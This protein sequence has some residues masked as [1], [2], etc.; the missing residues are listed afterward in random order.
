MKK[1]KIIILSLVSVVV[2]YAIPAPKYPALFS[3]EKVRSKKSK[4]LYD[5]SI[6]EKI[7]AETWA[8]ANNR[9]I[10]YETDGVLHELM[11]LENGKPVYYI[12]LNHNAAISTAANLVRDI[13]PYNLNGSNITV[14]VWD[15]GSVLSTHREFDGRV[16]VKDASTANYHATHVGGT[17]GAKGVTA[18]AKGM[19]P[20]SIIDSYD[21]NSDE[22]EMANRAASAPN[23]STKIYVSNHSY[24]TR[25][26]WYGTYWRSNITTLEEPYFGQYGYWT[27]YWDEIAYNAPYYLACKSSGNDRNDNPSNGDSITYSG[28]GPITY[29][30]SIHPGGDGNYK[31]GYDCIPTYG[32]AK[33]ILTVGAVNDAVFSGMRNLG[34]ATISSFSSWGP[35]DD[36]RIKPD[37]VGNGVGLYSCDDDHN[38]D[39]RSMSGTSMSSPNIC[40]SAALLIQHYR[41]LFPGD[42]MRSST[43]KGVI[44]HTADDI[45]RPGP[46]YCY[47]WGLMNTK[48]AADVI[49][50]SLTLS[51][52]TTFITEGLLD[53]GN[54]DDE[55]SFSIDGTEPFKATICW[56]D[57]PGTSTSSHDSRTPVLV[58]DL[59]LRIIS[60]NTTINY[61]FILD[62]NNPGNNATTGDNIRDNVEQ[63]I[64]NTGATPGSYNVTI[65]H[66][67]LSSI[68]GS[69][70][71]YSL[72]VS[73]AI[74]EPVGFLIF[75][76]LFLIYYFRKK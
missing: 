56:T 38:A 48:D 74:P 60:P 75:N 14:G 49:E 40:G 47:G 68:Y 55:F 64:I 73:G 37:I 5:K 22:A 65:N 51:D 66:K 19:A 17:I 45:G 29:D 54:P 59:D 27:R 31:S 70:Q 30:S 23:Q 16:T 50:K 34:F 58:N 26:G 42:D 63:V 61:P 2:L 44:L 69:H 25:S 53:S 35:T 10:R 6:K 36:G 72:I 18:S 71:Y 12:T 28:G 8:K 3:D 4:K 57:P 33:N 41:N 24:G 11:R 21:W 1:I 43:L 39:Y 32:N 15:G 62:Y 7:E 9:K 13:S 46:D 67:G 20:N 76:F 52:S